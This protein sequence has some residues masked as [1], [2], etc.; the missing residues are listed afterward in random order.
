[1]LVATPSTPRWAS[2]M[3]RY[4]RL[5]DRLKEMLIDW[6]G[7]GLPYLDRMGSTSR[8]PTAVKAAL[9]DTHLLKVFS[10]QPN[11]RRVYR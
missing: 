2:R 9:T 11:I 8:V 4:L 1:M 5:Q 6:N 3:P 7:Y 10:V